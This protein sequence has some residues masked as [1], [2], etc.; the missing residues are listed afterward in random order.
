MAYAPDDISNINVVIET[1][2]S[3]MSANEY[4]DLTIEG[5]ELLF[6]SVSQKST[7]VIG[8]RS[9]ISYSYSYNIPFLGETHG[10]QYIVINDGIAYIITYTSES[11]NDYITDVEAMVA[12]F[13]FK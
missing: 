4:Y 9:G 12:A 11:N 1:V 6:G 3:G 2:P 10:I 5:I 7:V 13:R 8:G